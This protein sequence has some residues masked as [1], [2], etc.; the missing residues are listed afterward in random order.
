[1]PPISAPW[2][3]QEADGRIF[4]Y[5]A[6]SGESAWELPSSAVA[7]APKPASSPLPPSPL[8]SPPPPPPPPPPPSPPPP[9]PAPAKYEGEEFAATSRYED[10]VA[11]L[12][13]SSS[14]APSPPAPAEQA[15]TTAAATASDSPLPPPP[16][17]DA[18]K[19]ELLTLARRL[20]ERGGRAIFLET[21]PWEMQA[22]LEVVDKLQPLD[23]AARDG[24][25]VSDAWDGTGAAWELR[26]TSSRT[27]HLN[28]GL[29]GYACQRGGV[30]TPQLTMRVGVPRRTWITFEEVIIRPNAEA[31]APG[32][33][34]VAECLWEAGPS[35]VLKV[36]A[37]TMRADG[38]E[39]TP[40]KPGETDE[41]DMSSEK[42]IRVLAQVVPVYLDEGLLVMRS[43]VVPEVCFVWT[44]LGA[45]DP[46][47]TD[48]GERAAAS[49]G[50]GA[51]EGVSQADV[52]A[53]ALAERDAGKTGVKRPNFG[54][55]I[56]RYN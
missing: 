11:A 22:V 6:E 45:S 2:S 21:P 48:L 32:D 27:F 8:P 44:R 15:A 10:A 31:A 19:A 34:C 46:P 4:F 13:T 55:G 7:A 1:M 18:L 12:D 41:V 53:R 40:R 16:Q 17:R 52:L 39:W 42:A 35:D 30:S 26:Y 28:E 49:G 43:A 54:Q 38:R 20:P 3:Q 50:G 24:W 51:Q 56:P 36:A 33:T 25:M 47:P 14:S 5:N 23:P 37:K 29:T 9:P